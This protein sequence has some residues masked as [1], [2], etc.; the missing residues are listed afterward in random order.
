M[1]SEQA[2][3]GHAAAAR[4]IIADAWDELE[5]SPYVQQK[6]G[7]EIT[8]IPEISFAEA[9]RKSF[10]GKS[11]LERLDQ[12]D[13]SQVPHET[14]VTLRLVRYRAEWWSN[15]EP[16]Y[17]LC[18]DPLGIG[19]PGMFLPSAY[20]GGWLLGILNS[21]I[22]Q[23][24]FDDANDPDRYLV[25]LSD[26]A[27][28]V[29]QVEERTALQADSGIFMPRP[30]IG[31]ARELLS[32]FGKSS[33]ELWLNGSERVSTGKGAFAAEV[34]RRVRQQLWPAFERTVNLL[35]GDYVRRAPGTVGLG[36]YPGG[37]E[38]YA[39][40]VKLHTTLD[41]AP[42]EIH[43]RGLDRM[44]R[45]SA[46]MASIRD[47]VGCDDHASF[48]D[49]LD[50]TETWRAAS[51]VE[52]AN[53]FQRYIDRMQ[54]VASDHFPIPKTACSAK[55]L[56]TALE[57]T[58]TY[59]YY[60]PPRADR[61]E[62][63]YFFNSAN[64]SKQLLTHVA[65]LTY[66]ELVPGHHLQFALQQEDENLEPFRQHS[67]V[68]AFNEGWAEYAAHFAGELGLYRGPAE[69]YG[70]EIMDAFLTSRL[71]VDTGMN[72]LGWPLERAR[73]YLRHHTGMTEAEIESETLRYSCD[74]PAQSLAYKLGD[75]RLLDIREKL[76]SALGDNFSLSRFHQ[77][78]LDVG[79]IP[80]PDLEWHLN[81]LFGGLP[82]MAS[83]GT[84]N[85]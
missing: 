32:R 43:A 60:D 64:L 67:F 78:I 74:I 72:V 34:R 73:E 44:A 84:Y 76:K 47:E 2:A 79:S 6:L 7:K 69:K 48:M 83:V 39:E 81:Q 15:E 20:C 19:V 4:E 35:G 36:Q 21:R 40:L 80:L 56:A 9:K 68:N 10:V 28:L 46:S 14:E 55:P 29:G 24:S 70:R 45:I 25:L 30:Q 49:H 22:A 27:R 5:K 37:A 53:V 54:E 82:A 41:L 11:L 57:A 58:M 18:V 66:H 62:G 71:V 12:I 77:A 52:I 63:I 85:G 26:Y 31:P 23:F 16:H 3:H 59:G 38:L 17:L 61:H 42:E 1:I 33:G 13:H 50:R 51:S 8:H 75:T 65:A